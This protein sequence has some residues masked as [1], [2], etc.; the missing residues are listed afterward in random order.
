MQ[1]SVIVRR[2]L[3][4]RPGRGDWLRSRYEIAVHEMRAL[5]VNF[6]AWSRREPASKAG[7]KSKLKH[8]RL[9]RWKIDTKQRRLHTLRNDLILDGMK[10]T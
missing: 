10:S 6:R 5:V 9:L 7:H 4:R 3:R 2:R 8:L 1:V